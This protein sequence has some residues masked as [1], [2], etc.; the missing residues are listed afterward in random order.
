MQTEQDS[1]SKKERVAFTL[2]EKFGFVEL[3]Y[4]F[5]NPKQ[6]VKYLIYYEITIKRNYTSCCNSVEKQQ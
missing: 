4:K 1:R 3:I 5:R 6:Y 2:Y